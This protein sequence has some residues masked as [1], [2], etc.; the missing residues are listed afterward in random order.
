MNKIKYALG[1]HIFHNNIEYMII[2]QISFQEILAQNII[3]KEK[4]ILSIEEI[5]KELEISNHKE[6]SINPLEL[7]S[8]DWNEANIRL[9]I[10]K[11]LLGVNIDKIRAI[12][13]RA[14][15]YNLHPTT[16]YRWIDAYEKSGN[17]LASLAPKNPAKGGKGHLRTTEEVELIIKKAIENLY[18]SKQKYSSKKTYMAIVQRCKNANIKPPSENTVRS[19]IQSLSDKEV[20]KRRE[21]ARMADR[22]YR[23]T[24]GMFPAGKYPLDFI[25]IDH[26]PMDII[27]VDEVYGQPIGRPYLTIAMDIYSRMVMGFFI[28]LD[29]PSYFSVSQCLTQAI[30][31]K[32][33]YLRSLEIDGEWNIWGIPKTIGL[34]NAA[35]FRG[36]DLQRVCEHYGIELNWRPVARPQFGGHIER[37]IGTA[38]REVH[39][40]PGT[41]FANIQQRGEY[42]SERYA[43]MT[44]KSLE[45]WLTEYIVNVYHKQIHSGIN[46]TPERKYELGIFGDNKA[47]LGRGLPERIADED[48]FKISLLTTVERTIQQSGIK[49]DG[50]QYYADSLR[51]WIRAKDKDKKA[52]KFI[53]KRDLRDISTIWFYDPDI[54]EYYPIPFR[55]MSYPPIS[56][57]DLRAVKKYLDE[58]NITG[59]DE[60]VI[61]SAY[62]KMKQIEKDSAQKVK[63]IR[64][65]HSAQK[66]RNNKKEFDNIPKTKPKRDTSYSTESEVSLSDLYKNIEPFD[67]IEIL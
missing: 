5:T 21:S 65:K 56:V 42:K 27:V 64:R 40:L 14:A 43:T 29:E 35:E 1:T 32:E 28:S 57:W 38:M 12:A 39:T 54:K 63:S 24:D 3:T 19:R 61:F 46:C 52:R 45:K 58:N 41:T 6:K 31:S 36:K 62:E 25:Q 50:I 51:R 20:L 8:K 16:I 11:P 33:K 37:I 7:N 44:L 67:D 47:V 10:I 15:E 23:N 22:K 4:V 18:L 55:N 9:E 26:T 30:L 2:R 17:L 66:H 59:Y 48:K 13:Q 53:F 34:D 49:V 60:T